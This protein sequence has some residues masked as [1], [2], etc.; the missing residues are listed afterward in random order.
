MALNRA[1]LAPSMPQKS[2][3]NWSCEEVLEARSIWSFEY[4]GGHSV[5]RNFLALAAAVVVVLF[6]AQFL[7]V[8]KQVMRSCA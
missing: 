2:N 4:P 7:L 5:L 6:F 8:K 3:G 1:K